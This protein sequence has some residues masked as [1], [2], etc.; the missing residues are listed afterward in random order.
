[1]DPFRIACSHQKYIKRNDE[2]LT[3]V[4]FDIE[5]V[6]GEVFQFQGQTPVRVVKEH[7]ASLVR[8]LPED[9][10]L[11]YAGHTMEN[12]EKLNEFFRRGEEA[13]LRADF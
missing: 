10:T 6:S 8:R 11:K 1:M 12:D 3:T 5:C 2:A 4:L 9:V 13:V 7:V